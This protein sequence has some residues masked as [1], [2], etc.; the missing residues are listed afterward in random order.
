MPSI[1]ETARDAHG[2]VLLRWWHR[3]GGA[4]APGGGVADLRATEAAR[5]GAE[6]GEPTSFRG[7]AGAP[8]P[9][10]M[11]RGMRQTYATEAG[12]PNLT[13]FATPVQAQQAFNREQARVAGIPLRLLSNMA[14][15]SR[16][17]GPW[18][19]RGTLTSSWKSPPKEKTQEVAAGTAMRQQEQGQKYISQLLLQEYGVPDPADKTGQTK[20]LPDYVQ[21]AMLT[22]LPDVKD[23][24]GVQKVLEK[25]RPTLEI[26][27]QVDVFNN[28][29]TG[30]DIR[31]SIL[32]NYQTDMQ[33]RGQAPDPNVV[34]FITSEPVT[35]ANL[36]W[37]RQ[38]ANNMGI[39]RVQH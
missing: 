30:G 11:I 8:A 5:N 38:R 20:I 31:S 39:A 1:L 24:G 15:L 9:V 18:R 23:M 27:K 26:G 17:V 2:K 29:A 3:G 35:A 32:A 37:F 16:R 21:K 6:L 10:G 14:S 13:E 7:G 22:V 12:G 19:R 4:P 34:R 33:A 25:I 36:P 28:K